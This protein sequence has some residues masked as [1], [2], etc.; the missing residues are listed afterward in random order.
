[1]V[2][3]THH[4]IKYS[5]IQNPHA[6]ALHWNRF[7]MSYGQLWEGV[8]ITAQAW[9][10]LDLSNN[11]RVAVW[12]ENCP[13]YVMSVF[14]ASMIG[15]AFVPVNPLLK[16]I[17]VQHILK[18]C[19][20]EILVTSWDRLQILGELIHEIA[21]LRHIVLVG[22][23]PITPWT[24]NRMSLHIWEELM[25]EQSPFDCP[26]VNVEKDLAA[27]LY[28]SGST[29]EP[30]GVAVSHRNLLVGAVSVAEYLKLHS[31]DRVLSALPLSF[32]VGLSQLTTAF[33]VGAA[34]IL[35]NHFQPQA[36]LQALIQEKPT[37]LTAV[38]SLWHRLL[39]ARQPA[40]VFS[41]LRLLA[42]TGGQIPL[43]T[44]K[45]LSRFAPNAHIFLMY[46]FTEAF[47]ST[48]LDFEQLLN[49]PNSIGKAIP[50]AQILVLNQNGERCGPNECGELVHRGPMVALG[51]WNNPKKTAT[52]FKP[53]DNGT[54]T[55]VSETVVYSGDTVRQDEEGYFYFIGRSDDMITCS[56]YRINPAEIEEVI[57]GNDLVQEAIAI[58]VD[59]PELGQSLVVVAHGRN[60]KIS[61]TC[62]M[63][64]RATRVY[65]T[66]PYHYLAK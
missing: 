5:A 56:G 59:H 51:Y 66:L 32:Y 38:P 57:Y 41:D 6:S 33:H 65:G 64:Q 58:G 25:G 21:S 36:V 44:L 30:K 15:A 17:Q 39:N 53:L 52:F 54:R 46:G 49:R 3:L 7:T 37:V 31:R 45:K 23:R 61:P 29:G 62:S 13:Q 12:Q 47:H 55:G 35:N 43:G 2:Y 10:Q 4:L 1:M 18:E 34:V 50:N 42:I 19:F 60:L 48:Y 22:R 11:S 9:H 40:Q 14:G 16:P 63:S 26:D 28:T 8:R 27:I 20:I 24:S